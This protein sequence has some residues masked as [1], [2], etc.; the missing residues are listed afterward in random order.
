MNNRSFV[1]ISRAWLFAG[2]L[3]PAL[4]RVAP[5]ATVPY[6]DGGLNNTNYSITGNPLIMQSTGTGIADQSGIISGSGT[7]EKTGAG[8]INLNATNTF[9]GTFTLTSGTIGIGNNAAFG[10]STIVINGGEI[11]ATGAARTVINA[12]TLNSSFTVGRLTTFNGNA[13]LGNNIT[14]TANNPG[15]AADGDS[16]FNGVISGSGRSVTLAEGAFGIGTGS[17]VFGGANTYTGGTTVSSGR[18]TIS[19]TGSLA[20]GS[21]L[22]VN[23]GNLVLNNSAQTVGAFSGSGGTITLG[24]GHALTVTPN[25]TSAYSGVI[26]GAGRLIKAGSGTLTLSGNN[27]YTGGI[28]LNNGTLALGSAGALNAAAGVIDF[29][30]GTLQY[31]AANTVDYSARFGSSAGRKFN[32]DTNGQSV[33]FATAL[34]SSGGTL[35]KLGAGTLTLTAANT[36]DGATTISGDHFPCQ[37]R[38]QRR[39]ARDLGNFFARAW[40]RRRAGAIRRVRRRL[41]GFRRRA[42]RHRSHRHAGLGFH[43][44]LPA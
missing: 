23:G 12:L 22:T 42:L 35:T 41:R 43:R 6:A 8:T 33:T 4:A 32:I 2:L 37:P 30:G 31:S 16:T 10:S 5:A 15:A 40:H 18:L 38:P 39:R 19:S 9:S 7:V 29:N 3:F 36:Y 28:V 21:A 24:I 34:A 26:A 11:R 44:E 13:A 20:S 1:R 17:I 14:I 27:S 25:T